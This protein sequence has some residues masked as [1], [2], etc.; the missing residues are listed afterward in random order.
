MK[1]IP[2]TIECFQQTP[3]F[4]SQILMKEDHS[5]AKE[6]YTKNNQQYMM[7]Y[8]KCYCGVMHQCFMEKKTQSYVGN[9]RSAN[10]LK[11]SMKTSSKSMDKASKAQKYAMGF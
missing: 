5:L 2:Q 10:E 8:G 9:T 3:P 7:F 4:L 6:M 1:W 11:Q